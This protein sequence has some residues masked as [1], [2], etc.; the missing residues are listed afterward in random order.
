MPLRIIGLFAGSKTHSMFFADLLSPEAEAGVRKAESAL[1]AFQDSRQL[2]PILRANLLEFLQREQALNEL[3]RQQPYDRNTGIGLQADVNRTFANFLTALRLYRDHTLT[4]LS[5]SYGRR[6]NEREHFA[7][8]W[9]A[10]IQN[11][12][13]F[14]FTWALRDYVQHCGLPFDVASVRAQS[15]ETGEGRIVE[16]GLHRGHLLE[17]YNRWGHLEAKIR[18]LP[19]TIKI[20]HFLKPALDRFLELDKSLTHYEQPAL[21]ALGR[22]LITLLR[23]GFADG[24]WPGTAGVKDDTLPTGLVDFH[25]T[26]VPVLA[27]LGLASIEDTDSGPRTRLTDAA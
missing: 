25:L 9:N 8:S 12:F 18:T 6:S 19:P 14:G 2:L 27:E 21:T 5:R 23:P 20:E 4:R 16:V 24:A 22:A 7:Q 11:H 17:R 13:P 1:E 3:L 26:P 10:A 15:P